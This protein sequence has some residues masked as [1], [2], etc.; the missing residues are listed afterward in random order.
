MA[1][2]RSSWLPSWRRCSHP[3]LRRQPPRRALLRRLQAGTNMLSVE[4]GIEDATV[5]ARFGAAIQPSALLR[6]GHGHRDDLGRSAATGRRAGRRPE[7]RHQPTTRATKHPVVHRPPPSSLRQGA[8]LDRDHY[9]PHQCSSARGIARLRSARDVSGGCDP[10]SVEFVAPAASFSV[11]CEGELSCS[12]KCEARPTC[13]SLAAA[14][15]RRLRGHLRRRAGNAP[16][17][18]V[19][20]KAVA[21]AAA[22]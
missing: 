3:G 17:A 18:R 1:G 7:R 10:G 16:A 12:G 9:Q 22:R 2:V 20:V 21:A 14:P 13:R 6:C 19:L 15:E 8:R 4:W 11:K 5:N